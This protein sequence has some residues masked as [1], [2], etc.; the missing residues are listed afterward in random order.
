MSSEPQPNRHYVSAMENPQSR[1]TVEER[2]KH[3]EQ[4]LDSDLVR[5]TPATILDLRRSDNEAVLHFEWPGEEKRF[6]LVL[7]LD[8]TG[9]EF[10][11]GRPVEDF[12]TWLEDFAV[13]VMTFF[14]TG[15]AKWARREDRGDYIAVFDTGADKFKR[16]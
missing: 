11:Y 9:E 5:M 10:Y 15:W 2:F 1:P 8:D 6:G 16:S 7:D 12:E 3:V 4:A 14:D 13:S